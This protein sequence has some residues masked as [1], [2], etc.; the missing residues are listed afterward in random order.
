[1]PNDPVVKP[2]AVLVDPVSSASLVPHVPPVVVKVGSIEPENEA[3]FDTMT[4]PHWT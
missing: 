4:L 3:P 2:P 1:V